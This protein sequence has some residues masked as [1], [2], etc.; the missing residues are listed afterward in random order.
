MKVQENLLNE[1]AN[2]DS[3]SKDD[4]NNVCSFRED[5]THR[6]HECIK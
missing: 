5:D 3:F 6:G 2:V 4:L 1:V